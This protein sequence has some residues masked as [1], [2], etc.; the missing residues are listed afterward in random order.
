MEQPLLVQ[1]G[2]TDR[3]SGRREEREEK[4]KTWLMRDIATNYQII[5]LL[6]KFVQITWKA[7]GSHQ[8]DASN[9]SWKKV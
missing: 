1:E 3:H 6:A 9:S 4:H 2:G 7:I 8:K 5:K